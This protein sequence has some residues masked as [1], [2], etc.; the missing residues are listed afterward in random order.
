MHIV[1]WIWRWKCL[2][3]LTNVLDLFTPCICFHCSLYL[4]SLHARF[5]CNHACYY[6]HTCLFLCTICLLFGVLA[7]KYIFVC[8]C[9]FTWTS[10]I[11]S[12]QDLYIT[13]FKMP[14]QSH[15]QPNQ[16]NHVRYVKDIC[17]VSSLWVH[18]HSLVWCICCMVKWRL[19]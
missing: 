17:I 6:L 2:C 15:S 16:G 19:M 1:W 9:V 11:H 8:V 10:F 4:F 13:P 12:F 3:E 5:L 7:F 14:T 18:L